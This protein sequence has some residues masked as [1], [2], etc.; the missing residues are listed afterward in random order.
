MKSC[1]FMKSCVNRQLI[2]PRFHRRAV[3]CR[4]NQGAILRD[5][6]KWYGWTIVYNI[7]NKNSLETF[8]VGFVTASQLVFSTIA[9]FSGKNNISLIKL[10]PD[11]MRYFAM[12]VILSIGQFFGNHFGNLATR[13]MS[14]S[15]VNI[16]KASEPILTMSVMFILFR[17]KQKVFK[18][19]L[20]FPII[21]GI[22]LCNMN[23]MTYNHY[24]GSMCIVSNLFHIFK[25]IVSKKYFVE[26]LGYHGEALYILSNLGSFVISMPFILCNRVEADYHAWLNLIISC[27]GYY[28]NSITAFDLITKVNPV[29]F[30]M[31]NIYKR[32]AITGI[33]YIIAMKIPGMA[34]IVGITISNVALYFYMR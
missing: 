10:P 22:C 21:A 25:I 34:T 33:C 18:I 19:F 8:D 13:L 30:S 32:V 23:D 17:Q 29:T 7:Y 20:V 2:L 27:F 12:I 16:V 28:Y 15:S 24:G 11:Y 5:T 31:L 3:I 6:A 4:A 26:V 9:T 1:F 14:I